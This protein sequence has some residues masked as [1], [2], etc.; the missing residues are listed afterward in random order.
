MLQGLMEA[1]IR[2]LWEPYKEASV[3]IRRISLGSVT[4][5]AISVAAERLWNA[6]DLLRGYQAA[7]VE[8][9][10][11]VLVRDPSAMLWRVLLPPIVEWRSRGATTGD[12]MFVLDGMHRLYTLHEKGATHVR[13]LTITSS[14][15]PPLPAHTPESW[16][17]VWQAEPRQVREEGRFCGLRRP[18]LRPVSE[19]VDRAEWEI[20]TLRGKLSFPTVYSMLED[21][22]RRVEQLLSAG[23][24]AKT[25]VGNNGDFTVRAD[26][27]PTT[28][29]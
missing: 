21:R 2:S 15:L 22:R 24:T 5:V 25:V 1:F 16:R 18:L 28:A 4:P 26:R 27:R 20:E 6:G 14:Q 11:P 13:G 8:P 10:E 7:R 3:V 12:E 19:T 17:Q 29:R 9:Y 23:S